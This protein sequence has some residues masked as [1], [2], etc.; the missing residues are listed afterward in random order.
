ME[1]GYAFVRFSNQV[2]FWE[3]KQKRTGLPKCRRL[4]LHFN[5]SHRSQQLK[6]KSRC[7]LEMQHLTLSPFLFQE[8]VE[9]LNKSH[10]TL[11]RAI[12]PI[13]VLSTGS[14]L[15][16]IAEVQNLHVENAHNI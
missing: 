6:Q 16:N 4:S 5:L 14:Q 1:M 7:T 11:K 3:Q 8:L 13:T 10:M 9:H 12:I 2:S 15:T